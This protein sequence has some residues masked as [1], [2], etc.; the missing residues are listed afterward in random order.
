MEGTV[1]SPVYQFGYRHLIAAVIAGAVLGGA[2]MKFLPWFGF[3]TSFE[4]CAAWETR[5][6]PVQE[7][8]RVMVRCDERF[9]VANDPR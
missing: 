8:A 5:R 3:Y 7:M 1:E 6:Q 4:E 2:A 9:P